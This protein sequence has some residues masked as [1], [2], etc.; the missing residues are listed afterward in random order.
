M[1]DH[2]CLI[3]MTAYFGYDGSYHPVPVN[4]RVIEIK[5]QKYRAILFRHKDKYFGNANGKIF[6]STLDNF[7]DHLCNLADNEKLSEI[8]Y[9]KRSVILE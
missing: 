2:L 1:L 4:T 3:F 7:R 5:T 6:Y 8:A 9:R